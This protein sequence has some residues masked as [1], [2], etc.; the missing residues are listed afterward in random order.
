MLVW[1]KCGMRSVFGEEIYISAFRGSGFTCSHILWDLFLFL[2][3]IVEEHH[4]HLLHPMGL[5]GATTLVAHAPRHLSRADKHFHW[6]HQCAWYSENTLNISTFKCITISC[7]LWCDLTEEKH[8]CI[9]YSV[10]NHLHELFEIEMFFVLFLFTP[11][12]ISWGT[13]MK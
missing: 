13:K 12:I 9:P 1:S 10:Y 8:V 11:W 6:L 5:Q 2:Q 7:C 4:P 3:Y